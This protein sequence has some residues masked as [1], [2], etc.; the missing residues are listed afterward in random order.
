MTFFPKPL[1]K[2]HAERHVIEYVEGVSALDQLPLGQD[3][4]LRVGRL[5]R[6]IQDASEGFGLPET[7]G[8]NLLL[9][10]ENPTL[11]CHNDLAPWN[12]IM[13][14]RWVFIDWDAAGPSTRLSD[15]LVPVPESLAAFSSL[16]PPLPGNPHGIAVFPGA[17]HGLFM[18]APDPAI[19]RASQLA[20]G[21]IPMVQSFIHK[22]T[23]ATLN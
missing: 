6:Q 7:T 19:D 13:G 1:G 22:N 8:W 16:L 23:S 17:G 18:E 2:D 20:P 21:L 11:M 5:I 9:P 4:L 15:A 10:A 12:L 3:D 14:E